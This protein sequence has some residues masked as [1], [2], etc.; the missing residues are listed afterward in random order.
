[1][2]LL[3]GT[4][5]NVT[6]L[7]SLYGSQ[8]SVMFLL[9]GLHGIRMLGYFGSY[10]NILIPLYGLDDK[11]I[12]LGTLWPSWQ[13]YIMF[14]LY[15]PHENVKFLLCSPHDNVMFLLYGL[16]ENVMVLLY[17]IYDTIPE[18]TA[19]STWTLIFSNSTEDIS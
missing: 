5:D 2:F 1:M 16:Y 9:Y 19:D 3:F 6:F 11:V 8:E 10:D 12:L 18:Q 14:L 15:G 7:V 4:H 17:S 13:R